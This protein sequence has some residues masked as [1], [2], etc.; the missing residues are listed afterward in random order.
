MAVI[1]NSA[2]WSN[3]DV[4]HWEAKDA[5]FEVSAI[6]VPA[7]RGNPFLVGVERSG[8]IKIGRR[9]PTGKLSYLLI[10]KTDVRAVS[11]CLIDLIEG[12]E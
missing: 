11:D 10:H 12:L 7:Q 3:R 4:S 1:G 6:A 8:T 2:S 5:E 9:G